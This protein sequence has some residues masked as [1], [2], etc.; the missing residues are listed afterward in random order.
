MAAYRSRHAYMVLLH[1][2]T[3]VNTYGHVIGTFDK[4]Y[5]FKNRKNGLA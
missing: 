5:S 3:Y 1:K 2:T 4:L